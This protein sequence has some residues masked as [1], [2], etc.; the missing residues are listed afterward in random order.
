M[1]F[2]C[3]LLW[4]GLPLFGAGTGM[5]DGAGGVGLLFSL[6]HV[7]LILF[8]G[9]DPISPSRLCSAW[10][11]LRCWD[12]HQPQVNGEARTALCFPLPVPRAG[13]WIP[14]AI[15]AWSRFV[16]GFGLAG[17]GVACRMLAA[18]SGPLFISEGVVLSLSPSATEAGA[19][20]SVGCC[21]SPRAAAGVGAAPRGR[22][23][24]G[25]VWA[26]RGGRAAMGSAEPRVGLLKTT[27]LAMGLL[28][29]VSV[30]PLLCL[31]PSLFLGWL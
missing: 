2:R 12:S 24:Q 10:L 26:P 13:C 18:E 29:D 27:G 7:S 30:P 31:V 4:P 9:G 15:P 8:P 3:V 1:C 23:A 14:A 28:S 17:S 20:I 5:R 16:A 21:G 22:G 19:R 6:L 25:K 11:L